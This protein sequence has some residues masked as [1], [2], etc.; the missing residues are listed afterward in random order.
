M[1]RRFPSSSSTTIRAVGLKRVIATYWFGR[2]T[3]AQILIFEVIFVTRIY[4]STN[5]QVSYSSHLFLQ[6]WGKI[7]HCNYFS[8]T[9]MCN[10]EQGTTE[11][12]MTS[13][14]TVWFG[15]ST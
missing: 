14:I 15:N 1:I 8:I 12:T 5:V 9:I 6:C 13:Y 3:A 10:F 7:S 11:N 4:L 2:R